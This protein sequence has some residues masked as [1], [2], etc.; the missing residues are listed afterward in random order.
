M[1][2]TRNVILDLLPMYLAD[3]VSSDTRTLIENYLETDPELA[4]LATKQ[5]SVISLPGNIP[6]PLTEEDKLKAYKKS[7]WLLVITIVALAFLIVAILGVTIMAF[8]IPA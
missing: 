4:E 6:V 7:K 2:I 5:K 8:L 3:E 1:K